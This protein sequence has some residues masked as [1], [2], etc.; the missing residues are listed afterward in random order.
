MKDNLEFPL[1]VKYIL[2]KKKYI[3]RELSKQNNLIQKNIAILGGSST[4]EIAN[5][6]EI[7]LLKNGI[8]PIFYQSEY[9]KYYEDALFS[10]KE[11]DK[12][13]PDIIY[14]HT[15]NKNIFKYPE[16]NDTLKEVNNLLNDE[17][18]KYQS[19]WKSLEKFECAI[20]QNNFDN[21]ENRVLGNLDCSDIH[22]K[23]Y[24]INKLNDSFAL[25]SREIKHLY[26]NDINYLS[27]YIGIKFWFDKSLWHQAKYALSF[28]SIPELAF[29]ISKII[30]SILGMAKKC[31]VLDLDNTCWGGVIGDD[32]INGIK[33]GSETAISES[34]TSFQ[35]FIKELHNRGITLAVCSKNELENAK[36]GFSHPETILTINDFASFKANWDPKYLNILEIASEINIGL[37]SLV[38]IDDN[39]VER[40]IVFS[41]TQSVSVPDIGNNITDYINHID[42]NGYFEP[43]SLS[44]DDLK[45]KQYYKDNKKRLS[46]KVKFES[47]QDFLESLNM[48]AEIKSFSPIYLDRITQLINKTNQFNLTTKRYT[49]GEIEK[50]FN[51]TKHIKIYGKLND[52]Y[53]ENG[54]ISI[55]VGSIKS[56]QC[57]VDLWLMSCRVLKRDMEFAMLDALVKK[58]K[59]N[60]IT[61]IIG[62]YFQTPKNIM[63]SNLYEKFGFTQS[64]STSKKSTWKLKIK[65]YHN[66]NKSIEVSN[67]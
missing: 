5:I 24:F 46:D 48:S 40:D 39:P 33:I 29:N 42:R 1:N 25:H 31:L 53:G 38:F 18:Q 63:V 61:E 8:K 45:R 60:K 55:I 47:Y 54:V 32:G 56:N 34:Y 27:S 65:N 66:K 4:S 2:R 12:F 57:H 64:E 28:D 13:N 62:Y 50:V 19:I 15:T 59:E 22:G 52:K 20:I 44:N 9:N 58:S 30:S 37:D 3:K 49:A 16:I 17:I 11:L 67:E 10:N 51:S 7:F 14:I 43:I 23:T 41:Q 35:K 21:I 6:L 26:I 36:E